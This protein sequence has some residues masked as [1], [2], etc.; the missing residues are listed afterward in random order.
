MGEDKALL[1]FGN[2]PT[3]TQYQLSRL[4]KLF[5][6]VYISCKSSSKFTFDANFIEDVKS[7]GV[8]A[9]TTGFIS[10][11]KELKNEEKIFV[12][13]VD[14]PFISEHEINTIIN[15]DTHTVDAT[16]ART[17]EGLQPMCGIYHKSL[18]VKFIEMLNKDTHRLGYLLQKSTTTY[19]SFIDSNPF[20]N[21][22][23]PQDYQ[24]ALTLI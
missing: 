24:K 13:S 17:E 11:F 18:E 22:N 9:P 4:Q 1:P 23:N 8:F 10:I 20:L 6:N 15:N 14:S 12:I 19:V 21:L 7:N 2:S 16:I 3:L 5:T